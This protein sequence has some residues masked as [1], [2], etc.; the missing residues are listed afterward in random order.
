MINED[1][2][3]IVMSSVS[4]EYEF[5]NP[6]PAS[7]EETHR[8][9]FSY[10]PEKYDYIGPD[11]KGYSFTRHESFTNAND[12]AFA[13]HTFLGLINNLDFSKIVVTDDIDTTDLV[14]F[15]PLLAPNG[16]FVRNVD[17]QLFAITTPSEKLTEKNMFKIYRSQASN[18]SHGFVI[19]QGTKYATVKTHMNRYNLVMQDLIVGDSK[20]TQHFGLYQIPG[21]NR[22]SMYSLLKNPWEVCE[23]VENTTET[24]ASPT[25]NHSTTEVEDPQCWPNPPPNEGESSE[26]TDSVLIQ[27]IQNT[28][29]ISVDSKNHRVKRFWSLYDADS[30]DLKLPNWE[31]GY[32]IGIYESRV[33]F[34]NMVKTNGNIHNTKYNSVD[35]LSRVGNNYLFKATF[36]DDNDRYFMIGYDGKIRWVKYYN[37]FFNKFFNSDV[38]P[39]KIIEDVKPSVIYECPYKAVMNRESMKLNFAELKDVMTP[40]YTYTTKET[41]KNG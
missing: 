30:S 27:N 34:I 21:T 11:G 29:G 26:E 17:G 33:P 22:I 12:E 6:V 15:T 41:D 8:N 24:D 19:G 1:K 25:A 38:T 36:F 31:E 28:V 3:D 4:A 7:A 16:N 23:V 32:P 40:G 9:K 39:D 2:K 10:K 37:E 18:D 20:G 5:D 13:N 14:L 35:T